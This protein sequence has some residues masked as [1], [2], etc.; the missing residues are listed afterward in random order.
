MDL[1]R[2]FNMTSADLKQ[3]EARVTR[4]EDIL[5]IETLQNRYMHWL[6]LGRGDKIV[7]LFALKTSGVSAEA[8]DSGLFVGIE[9]I[10]RHFKV[11]S[12]K[13]PVIG[14]YAENHAVNPVIEV[15]EDG[16]TA[17]GVWFVP[18][19]VAD[20]D[21]KSQGWTFGK[22]DNDYVKE[23]GKWKIWHLHWV[24]TFETEFDKGW[25]YQQEIAITSMRLPPWYPPDK[26]TTRHMPYSPYRIN[27]M[28]PEPPE[29]E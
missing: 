4:L 17:K 8:G 21:R 10:K 25:L 1:E 22:Y 23:G 20:P 18:G 14:H 5:E 24:Q 11:G 28:V 15:A 19:M 16:K 26:E 2:K 27:Y 7:D 29:P 13:K 12:E 9:G 6:C 3:L